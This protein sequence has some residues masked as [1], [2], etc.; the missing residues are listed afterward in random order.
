MS[1]PTNYKDDQLDTSVNDKRHYAVKKTD[2]DTTIHADVYLEDITTYSQNGTTLGATDINAIT[3]AINDLQTDKQD[4]STAITTSNIGSQ[5]V[6][7]A[8]DATNAVNADKATKDGSGN[9]IVSTYGN[10]LMVSGSNN[11]KIALKD[12]QGNEISDS[13]I[14]VPYA[15]NANSA[16][17]ASKLGT[18]AG[19]SS[20]PVYFSNGVPVACS[21]DIPSVVDNLTSDS[22]TSALSAKQGKALANGSA[23]DN[24]KLPLSG[25]TMTGNLSIIGDI[26]CRHADVSGKLKLH[27]VAGSLQGEGRI[28]W[29]HGAYIT[30]NNSQN[31][32]FIAQSGY[33]TKIGVENST[34]TYQPRTDA[35]MNL[36]S[37]NY[38]WLTVFAQTGTINTS[39]RNLKKEIKDLTD[40]QTK[41][42]VMNLKPVEYQFTDG[43][44]GR[45]HYGLIAQDVEENLTKLGLT[46]KDFA[47]LCIDKKYKTETD[48]DGNTT[49]VEDGVIY[50][51]RYEEFIA[52]LI[53]MV[54][55]QQ[56]QIDA[57]TKRIDKLEKK[58]K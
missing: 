23:R 29:T 4:A 39:D 2:D 51:L 24:T 20:K 15:T 30:S 21:N 25:G 54:Q 7:S 42:F 26:D 11:N 5:S 31:M 19:S 33:G 37:S 57:L 16:V 32:E 22:T 28:E 40:K 13:A 9:T 10:K 14:T 44:S 3:S 17:T 41:D 56:A 53:K 36:G 48:K 52:P 27:T 50:G 38:R 8:T 45:T 46:S 6:A 58:T 18:N 12:K 1:L 43:Q 35:V 49:E 47:G 55:M 34:W